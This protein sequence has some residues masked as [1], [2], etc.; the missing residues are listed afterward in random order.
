MY[1]T[2]ILIRSIYEPPGTLRD[3]RRSAYNRLQFISFGDAFL[4]TGA[5]GTIAKE[6]SHVHEVLTFFL[7]IFFSGCFYR[8]LNV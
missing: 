8:L 3:V 1:I 6:K 2:H 5:A 7:R 4:Y